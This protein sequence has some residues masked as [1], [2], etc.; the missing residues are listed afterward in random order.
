MKLLILSDLHIGNQFYRN[1][2]SLLKYKRLLQTNIKEDY[3]MVVISG[4]VFQHTIMRTNISPYSILNNLFNGKNVVFCLGNHQFAFESY[5]DVIE[6]W[7][8]NQYNYNGNNVFC[9][10]VIDKV[11][12]NDINFV[13]NVF[14]YDFSMNK[15]QFLMNGQIIE[16]WLDASI[17]NFDPIKQ[18]KL[19]QNKILSSLSKDKRNILVTHMV[20]H[21]TLNT[22]SIQQECS[23]YNAYSGN[24]D[25][26]KK[27]KSFNIEYAICGHTHKRQ[28]KQIYNIKCI[29]I[30]NDYVFKNGKIV[31]LIVEV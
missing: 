28:I 29:N 7:K 13:G 27:I 22:F 15:N 6:Y 11:I 30:G 21:W 17:Q 24:Y 19:C 20:P 5:N 23:M 12:I 31:N 25:F 1:E 9:L 16:N 18:N 3:D 4:D 26:L 2:F 14:W 8:K 10:D